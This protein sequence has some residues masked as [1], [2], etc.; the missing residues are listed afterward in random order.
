L[1]GLFDASEKIAFID[2]RE[3]E[4]VKVQLLQQVIEFMELIFGVITPW[5]MYVYMYVCIHVCM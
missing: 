5:S 4:A 1:K 2:L 3:N